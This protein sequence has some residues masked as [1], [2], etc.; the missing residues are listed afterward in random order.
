M[1]FVIVLTILIGAVSCKNRT[2]PEAERIIKEWTGKTVKFP[3]LPCLHSIERDTIRYSDTKEYKI[4]LYV[5]STGCMGCKLRLH[6]WMSY[7]DGLDSL[8]NFLF[9]FHPQSKDELF[10]LFM[11]TQFRYYIYIDNQGELDKLN[12]FPN[13][14]MFNCFLLDQNNKVLAIGDPIKNPKIWDLYKQIITGKISN[15]TPVTTVESSQ[16]EIDLQDLKTGKTSEAVF[17]LTNTGTKPLVIRLVESSC[18]CTVPE[19]EKQPIGIGK[20]TEIRVKITPDSPEYFNKTV[21][22]HCNTEG[23]QVTFSIRGTVDK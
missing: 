7:M 20:S 12:H 22:I 2:D 23:G 18:G 6:A 15:K 19:W 16:T 9:Y 14:P 13:N 4:L 8:A 1:R 17:V 10:D 11:Q 21:T 5:D 3:E